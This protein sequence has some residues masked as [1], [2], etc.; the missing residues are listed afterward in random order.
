MITEKNHKLLT[1][2]LFVTDCTKKGL[3]SMY[4]CVFIPTT[5]LNG[6]VLFAIFAIGI[7]FPCRFHKNNHSLSQKDGNCIDANHYDFSVIVT[8]F[9]PKL[10]CYVF[11]S[12]FCIYFFC[13]VFIWSLY[14]CWFL[15]SVISCLLFEEGC[16]CLNTINILQIALSS[17]NISI[18]H[19]N[20]KKYKLFVSCSPHPVFLCWFF[21]FEP[22][23][24]LGYFWYW[25]FT[26][27]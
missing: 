6:Q 5:V 2:Q 9:G 18:K 1:S 24:Y 23:C 10:R 12:R 15:C 16:Q 7:M 19:I 17:Q 20:I 14:N 22:Q 4:I 11:Y 27:T 25:Y 21:T 8:N 26:E 13:T 3:A